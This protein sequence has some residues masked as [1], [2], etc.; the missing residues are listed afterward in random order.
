MKRRSIVS[1]LFAGALASCTAV[2]RATPPAGAYPAELFDAARK[3][4][5]SDERLLYVADATT[6][7]AVTIYKQ[8]GHD[9]KPI[10]YLATDLWFAC[11][12]WVDTHG[13]LWVANAFP[14]QGSQGNV[15][16]VRFP[17]GSTKPDLNIPDPTWAVDWIWV[18]RHGDI[19]VVNNGY[20]SAYQMLEFSGS[21][22]SAHIIS[23][24]RLRSVITSIVGDSKG[25]LFV[26]GLAKSGLGEI[27]ERKAGSKRW[28]NTGIAIGAPG[29]LAIDASGNLV[30][31]DLL[32]GVIETFPPEQTK[33]SSTITC[34]AY[35][36][37]FAFNRDGNRIWVNEPGSGI[38]TV[39][40][41]T[42]PSGDLIDS[43]PQPQ[44]SSA[45]GVATSPD[46]YP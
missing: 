21:P 19:F 45:L 39:D 32:A 20:Y 24:P 38:N 36:L 18:N 5:A 43:L 41:L 10:G 37:S 40:E 27:D 9:Q 2:Q 14:S 25:D 6:Y 35:C 8:K 13:N 33:P 44:G 22:Y 26:S 42:Y 3:P 30:A 4:R 15:T 31:S 28:H 46:L 23:D 16:I 29:G 7:T 12:L 34:T 17:R 1:I 11:G